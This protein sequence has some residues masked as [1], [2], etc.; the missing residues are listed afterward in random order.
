MAN[1]TELDLAIGD[2][3]AGQQITAAGMVTRFTDIETWTGVVAGAAVNVN[4][5]KTMAA[6]LPMGGYKVTGMGDGV[7][8]TDAA[9]FGQIATALTALDKEDTLATQATAGIFG[10]ITQQN[11]LGDPLAKNEK[12]LAQSDGFFI[13]DGENDCTL[14]VIVYDTDG[15]TALF[16]STINQHGSGHH[17]M[18]VPKLCYVETA[19]DN[20]CD[21]W[22][23]P[24]GTGGLVEQ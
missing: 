8:D 19:S 20:T 16:D 7:S 23:V 1:I 24:I 6:A 21:L 22:W 14:R 18:I 4:G 2:I 17:N 13:I 10:T 11:T 5:T 9:A 15:D 12:Y 3:V